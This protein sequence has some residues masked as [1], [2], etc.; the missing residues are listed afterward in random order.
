MVGSLEPVQSESDNLR[1]ILGICRGKK[2]D[3]IKILKRL[4]LTGNNFSYK[5]TCKI[6][7]PSTDDHQDIDLLK[8]GTMI[9]K[10]SI[11]NNQLKLTLSQSNKA[12]FSIL[13]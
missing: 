1:N 4:L 9:L 8:Y 6:Q 10:V 13:Y 11:G 5:I 12:H 2:E 7:T 3:F